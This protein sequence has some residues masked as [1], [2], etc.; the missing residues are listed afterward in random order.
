MKHRRLWMDAISRRLG[1][2][3]VMIRDYGLVFACVATDDSRLRLPEVPRAKAVPLLG[4]MIWTAMFR[5]GMEELY[6]QLS[7]SPEA[8]FLDAHR[9]SDEAPTVVLKAERLAPPRVETALLMLQ[10][11]VSRAEMR[12]DLFDQGRLGGIVTGFDGRRRI[13]LYFAIVSDHAFFIRWEKQYC[14]VTDTGTQHVSEG[15]QGKGARPPHRNPSV[16]PDPSVQGDLSGV[17]PWVR[18]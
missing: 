15:S 11:I 2:H 3:D 13:P 7:G 4:Q 8:P 10:H 6:F 14:T 16:S 9:L 17:V 5:L 1:R 18:S 12:P